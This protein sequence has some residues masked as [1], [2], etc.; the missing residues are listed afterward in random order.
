MERSS[1]PSDIGV[2]D[3]REHSVADVHGA[4]AVVIGAGIIGLTLARRLALLGVPGHG[5]RF[6]AV[7]DDS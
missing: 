6:G 7:R 5:V 2:N 1:I 3:V 4:S